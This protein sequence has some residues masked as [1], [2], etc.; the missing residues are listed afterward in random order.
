MSVTAHYIITYLITI[1]ALIFLFLIGR[2]SRRKS[3]F[4]GSARLS[5]ADELLVRNV[6][7]LHRG[8]PSERALVLKLLKMG[9]DPRAIFHD[10]YLRKSGGSYTQVD[11]VVATPQGLIVFEVKDYSGW[12][13]GNCRDDYWTQI[14]SYGQKRI[15]FYNP[16]KQNA[17]HI[18]A[19]RE[20]LPKNPGVPI[21]SVVVFYGTC[22]LKKLTVSTGSAYVV[23]DRDVESVVKQ[24][25]TLHPAGYQDKTEIMR[26]MRKAVDNGDNSAIVAY[27]QATASYAQ[28]AI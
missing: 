17:A 13:F 9:I 7:P 22:E 19:I 15:R 11:L 27:Q 25:L 10:C 6:T 23:Y 12:I 4:H 1:V 8:E 28:T 18:Q 20:N 14:L 2:K 5:D 26:V 21:F 3:Y 16:V 24:I